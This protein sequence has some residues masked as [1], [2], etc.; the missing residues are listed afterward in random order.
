MNC[1]FMEKSLEKTSNE[2][3]FVCVGCVINF[4]KSSLV[5]VV[6]DTDTHIY[7]YILLYFGLG[8]GSAAFHQTNPPKRCRICDADVAIYFIIKLVLYTTG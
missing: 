6:Y 4:Y 5:H 2:Y 1:T 8:N 7:Q 3:R